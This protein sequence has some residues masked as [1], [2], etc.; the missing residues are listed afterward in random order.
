MPNAFNFSI[1]PFDCLSPDEQQLVRANVDVIRF[2]EG[3][4]ILD[5]GSAPTAGMRVAYIHSHITIVQIAS[6][7]TGFRISIPVIAAPR[8][9]LIVKR[10]SPM[11]R[12]SEKLYPSVR[13]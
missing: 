1:S 11:T 5:L 13:S 12:G 7:T 9:A 4:I 6:A 3:Q 10:S 8:I 2:Q